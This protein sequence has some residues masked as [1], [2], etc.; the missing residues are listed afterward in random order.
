MVFDDH[1]NTTKKKKLAD[2]TENEILSYY[3]RES[4][5]YE[6]NKCTY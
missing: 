1:S 3:H 2:H 4:K 6:L 5:A